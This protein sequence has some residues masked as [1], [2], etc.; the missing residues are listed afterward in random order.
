MAAIFSH[1]NPS[2]EIVL[3]APLFIL[4]SV[5]VGEAWARVGSLETGDLPY[6]A[7]D[8]INGDNRGYSD[9]AAAE[10]FSA[11][12]LV[13]AKRLL[14]LVHLRPHPNKLGSYSIT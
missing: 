12:P 3:V 6:Q 13:V 2:E 4:A 9:E 5:A 11:R 10:F 8:N 14:Q 7:G 1:V